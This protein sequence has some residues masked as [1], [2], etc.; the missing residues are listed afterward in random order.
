MDILLVDR[1]PKPYTNFPFHAH[2]YWEI[3]LNLSGVGTAWI[4]DDAVPFR[5]GTILCIPPDVRHRKVSEHGFIDGCVFVKDYAPLNG[6]AYEVHEDDDARTFRALHALALDQHLRG[7]PHAKE[8]VDALGDAMHR[9]LEGWSLRERRRSPAV[10]RFLNALVRGHADPAFDLAGEV[11]RTGYCPRYFRK[12][13]RACTGQS[14]LAYLTRLRIEAAK[15]QLQQHHGV[16]PIKEIALAT[17]FSDPYY[18]SRAFK[19][20]EG[21]SPQQYGAGLGA[22]ERSKIFA[23]VREE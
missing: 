23:G 14:P 22:Y 11:K 17:G 5:E 13:F 6:G 2:G 21:V 1:S 3:I 15:R 18:F 20:L 16:H 12:L 4:G 10:D 19:R 7:E 9:L 8:V